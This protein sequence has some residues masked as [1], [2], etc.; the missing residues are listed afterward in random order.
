MERVVEGLPTSTQPR[1]SLTDILMSSAILEPVGLATGVSHHTHLLFH[2]PTLWALNILDNEEIPKAQLP[3]SQAS[4]HKALT[5]CKAWSLLP[6][7]LSLPGRCSPVQRCG[8]KQQRAVEMS[9]SVKCGD[10]QAAGALHVFSI[11]QQPCARPVQRAVV[12][13]L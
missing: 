12:P 3:T 5:P 10:H 7:S 8:L 9:F 6:E 11:S 13:I 2:R 1:N 4:E